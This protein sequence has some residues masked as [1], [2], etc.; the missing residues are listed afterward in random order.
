M[1]GSCNGW[2][3]NILGVRQNG[4]VVRNLSFPT[5]N[6]SSPTQINLQ[7]YKPVDIIVVVLGSK[8][9]EVGFTVRAENGF[10][11]ARRFEG[12]A[13]YANEILARFSPNALNYFPVSSVV[14]FNEKK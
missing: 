10:I 6:I 14:Q 7:R 11:V 8:T 12:T 13:F 5:G 3:N 2:N 1:T 4:I 9:W